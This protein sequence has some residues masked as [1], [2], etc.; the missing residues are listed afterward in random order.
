[1]KRAFLI[2]LVTVAVSLAGYFVCYEV[3]T[4]PAKALLE[5][6]QCGMHWLREE[7]HLT[8]AQFAR[9]GQLHEAYRPTCARMCSRVAVAHA[10]VNELI[11]ANRTMTAETQAA[12]KE[13]ALLQN[14]CSQAMLQHVYAVSAEMPP[15]QGQRYLKMAAARIVTPGMAHTSLLAK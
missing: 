1:M 11:L 14:E 5:D 7:Y 10:R 2:L 6:P 13:W 8:D 15:E 9:I 3:A 12:L 4:R